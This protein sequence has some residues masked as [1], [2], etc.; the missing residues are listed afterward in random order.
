MAKPRFYC[1]AMLGKLAR[2]L[3]MLGYDTV[4]AADTLT[5]AEI[6]ARIGGRI[7]LTRDKELSQHGLRIESGDHFEQVC[8]LV[9]ELELS[10]TLAAERCSVCNGLLE[11]AE[12]PLPHG[13]TKGWL[14]TRC[15]QPYWLGSHW[16]EMQVFVTRVREA[17]HGSDPA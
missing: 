4:F 13:I 15:G 12:G 17:T 2:W 16:D 11:E 9:R 7:L 6:I 8:Q 10:T 3:R 14:C 1:D 5:D